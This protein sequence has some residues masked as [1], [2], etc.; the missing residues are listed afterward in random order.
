MDKKLYKD[1]L[2]DTMAS[3]LDGN[4]SE[5]LDGLMVDYFVDD[6]DVEEDEIARERYDGA[7]AFRAGQE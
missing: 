3:A 7:I 1:Y 6:E 2:Y 5:Y 4:F